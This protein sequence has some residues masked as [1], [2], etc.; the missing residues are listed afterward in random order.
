[1]EWHVSVEERY[2]HHFTSFFLKTRS[3]HQVLS[4]IPSTHA[5]QG[6][7]QCTN[8]YGIQLQAEAM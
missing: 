5:Y 7:G 1:M 4:N 2:F 8:L 6:P 3:M